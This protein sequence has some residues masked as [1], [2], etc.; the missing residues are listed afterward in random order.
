VTPPAAPAPALGK[1][2]QTKAANRAAILDAARA[3]FAEMG[4]GAA[5]IRDVI[6]RT[7]LST[8]TFYNYFPDKESV[9][10]ALVADNSEELRRRVREARAEATTLDE[11]VGDAYRAYFR[12]MAEDSATFELLRR[13][14]G[15]IRALL[16]TPA[17]GA[18]VEDLRVD[19]E[20]AIARGELPPF[21]AEYMADAM[22]GVG[23]ELAI[24]MTEREPA[25][26]DAA[27]HFA[28]E[29]FLGGIER[30]AR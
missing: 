24:R 5:T 15:T 11:F 13:N 6:R 29:I 30:L 26:P 10:R 3:V 8:G 27:A 1:R 2:E 23:F 21:D 22:A 7:G 9:L 16:D 25:D 17:F 18:G 4:Y 28:T 19:L 14:A 20:N 12:F